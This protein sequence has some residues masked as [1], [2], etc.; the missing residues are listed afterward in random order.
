MLKEV[1]IVSLVVTVVFVF[2]P[3]SFAQSVT[4]PFIYENGV[5]VYLPIDSASAIFDQS[6]P[7]DSCVNVF[8][9]SSQNITFSDDELKYDENID[10]VSGT[11]WFGGENLCDFKLKKE[12]IV[13]LDN[14]EVI[15]DY[16]LDIVALDKS[17]ARTECTGV[18]S[19]RYNNWINRIQYRITYDVPYSKYRNHLS[20]IPITKLTSRNIFHLIEFKKDNKFKNE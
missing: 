1:F 14:H 2:S 19:C 11:V 17:S 15:N 10:K 18:Y 9:T 3:I 13:L 6:I 8:D 16:S 20:E 4:N 5:K 12:N 7:V